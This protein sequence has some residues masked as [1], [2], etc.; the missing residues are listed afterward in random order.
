MIVEESV[1]VPIWVF[2]AYIAGILTSEYYRKIIMLPNL[3]YGHHRNAWCPD[4]PYNHHGNRY[5]NLM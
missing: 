4:F 1:E 2:A 5:T 3:P